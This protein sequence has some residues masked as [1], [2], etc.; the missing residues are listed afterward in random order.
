MVA[1]GSGSILF[2]GSDIAHLP[3]QDRVNTGLSLTR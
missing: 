2:V 3:S 1:V